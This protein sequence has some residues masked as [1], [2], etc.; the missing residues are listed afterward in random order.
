MYTINM[1]SDKEIV[2]MAQDPDI[3]SS[4]IRLDPDEDTPDIKY[5]AKLYDDCLR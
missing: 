3:A 2:Y 1:E 5:E 4:P